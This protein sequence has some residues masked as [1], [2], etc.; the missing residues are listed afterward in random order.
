[1][2]T[3]QPTTHTV[4]VRMALDTDRFMAQLHRAQEAADRFGRNLAA[5]RALAQGAERPNPTIVQ[6][7]TRTVTVEVQALDAAV[8]ALTALVDTMRPDGDEDA[9]A[10]PAVAPDGDEP[11]TEEPAVGA[12]VT[13]LDGDV[14]QRVEDG[15]RWW[16]KV[17]CGWSSWLRTWDSIQT[18][19]GPLRATTD[20]DRRRVGLPVRDEDASP[21]PAMAPESDAEPDQAPDTPCERCGR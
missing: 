12:Q 20:D 10:R 15:W 6:N 13:D 14:W 1:M 7:T 17:G 11:A 3:D 8:T 9:P 4:T 16:N 18:D 5:V 19:Y 2:S 21:A